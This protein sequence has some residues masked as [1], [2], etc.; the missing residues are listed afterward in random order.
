MP[1]R[2]VVYVVLAGL[3]PAQAS[4]VCPP[5]SPLQATDGAQHA[6]PA[7]PARSTADD[8]TPTRAPFQLIE[9]ES[10]TWPAAAQ[11]WALATEGDTTGAG[12]VRW[13]GPVADPTRHALSL[14]IEVARTDAYR[15]DVRHA[16]TATQ[17]PTVA[18][19]AVDHGPWL[20]VE[21]GPSSW[22][23]RATATRPNTLRWS[24]LQATDGPSAFL[25]EAGPHVIQIA[26]AV[27]D[28]FVDHVALTPA[29]VGASLTNRATHAAAVPLD[30]PAPGDDQTPGVPADDG[31]SPAHGGPMPAVG[32]TPDGTDL[33]PDTGEHGSNGSLPPGG[34]T[35]GNDI[36]GSITT[37]AGWRA[38][39][40]LR[41]WHPLEISFDG[42]GSNEL[43]E[44]P[45]PFLDFRLQVTFT[46]PQGQT[47]DVPGFFDGDGAGGAAGS[48]WKVRFAPDTSGWWSFRASFRQG[49][50]V[51]VSLAPEAGNA[52]HFDGTRGTFKVF[53]TD[54]IAPGFLKWGRLEYVGRHY[55]KFREGPYFL[56][57]GTDSPENFLA[58]EGFDDIEDLGNQGIIHEYEEH[59]GDWTSN[60]PNFVSNDGGTDAK[61]I[62]GALN[63][64]SA[65]GVN[66]VYFLPMNLGGDG[67][68]TC[69]FVGYAKTHFNKTHYDLSR[70]Q[71]WAT[72]FDHA[73]RKGIQLHVVLAETETGNETWLD[74]G[75]LGV[76]RKLF[77]RE[78]VARFGHALALKWNLCEEADFFEPDDLRAHAQYLDAL[79]AYDHPIGVHTFTFNV[80]DYAEYMG[81]PLF[82]ISSIQYDT[83]DAGDHVETWRANSEF[84]GRRWV[85]DMDEN[86]PATEGL[87][88]ANADMLRKQVLYDVYF[89]GGNI[90]WY[91]GSH[92]LPLGGDTTLEDFRTREAMWNYTR[93]ARELLQR[94][95]SFWNMQPHDELLTGE[96]GLY[97]GG[98]VFARLGRVYAVYLPD[99]SPS[100]T[101]DLTSVTTTLQKQWY[102][103]RNGRFE[104]SPV[105]V[106]GG[107][108]HAL[109]APPADPDEDWVCLLR[110]FD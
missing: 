23:P 24:P 107:S 79:D 2:L 93:Y 16:G 13:S 51:A 102:N 30:A 42:P 87:T 11:R 26:A 54:P 77:F 98:E 76:E 72:V 74:G 6:S 27:D 90:E 86:A 32:A 100:G 81:D 108:P 14:S 9:A 83:D 61:G 21:H 101:L 12:G 45:N 58:Y 8:V 22:P 40:V 15:I 80:D 29:A 10:G 105:E 52:S 96:S 60:D 103:P 43:A 67:R 59:I 48:V 97:G 39:D 64:L 82:S 7:V 20:A 1:V 37:G 49:P 56:K 5:I 99:A 84:A 31:S 63:Y 4:A 66:S 53:R 19:V 78:L 109:G 62:L 44:D 91:L 34:S 73:Q 110:S 17:P 69:P 46:G 94:G 50:D 104:G 36:A 3:M 57:S 41:A 65:V 18:W 55:L 35:I 92:G 75:A 70:M 25:L 95:T 68:D 28:L 89:S 38:S 88:D 33:P 85:I 71:Q 47:Y 106:P